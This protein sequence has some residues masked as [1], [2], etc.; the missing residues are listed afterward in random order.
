MQG[1]NGPGPFVTVANTVLCLRGIESRFVTLMVGV[2]T[3]EGQLTYTNAGHNPP[4]VVGA[5]GVRRLEE[6]GPVVGML[7]FAR[8]TQ[9]TVPLSPGDIIVV[10]SDGV[11]EAENK[12]GEEFGDDRIEAEVKAADGVSADAIVA[13]VFEAVR[14]FTAGTAAGDDITAMVIRYLGPHT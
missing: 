10:F 5:S 2:I 13:R 11:S 14:A 7:D 3:A 9:A 1:F 6:G 4:F 8:F 12:A